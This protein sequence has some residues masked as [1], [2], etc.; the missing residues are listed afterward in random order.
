MDIALTI[1]VDGLIYGAWLF[2]VAIGLT[3]VFG[4]MKILNVAHGALYAVGAYAGASLVGGYLFATPPAALQLPLLIV[5]ALGVALLLGPLLEGV[6]LRLFYGRDEVVILLATFALSLIIE[7]LIKQVWGVYSYY[8]SEPYA[9]FGVIEAG[10][11]F[12]VG[13]DAFLIVVAALVGL[14]ASAFLRLTRQGKIVVAM[15]HDSEICRAMGVNV[16]RAYLW[17]F[18]VGVFLAA[19]AGA[20]IAPTLAVTPTM[21]VNAIILSFAVVVIGGLGS[22][23]G[24]ALGA[25]IVGCTRAATVH[26]WPEGELFIVYAVM[27]AVLAVRPRGLFGMPEGRK[28]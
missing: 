13:Y 22:V 9:L 25:L 3:L 15:I 27:A 10:P 6:L 11:L 24:A 20:L 21:G 14:G 4:I 18:T 28:I 5:A 23:E 12:Y 17:T 1:L 16:S 26:L 7:D 19:L 8:V 2:L